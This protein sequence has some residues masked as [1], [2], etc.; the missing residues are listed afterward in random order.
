MT[1]LKRLLCVLLTLL[2]LTAPVAKAEEETVWVLC[3]PGST[4]NIRSRP[5][6]R[7]EV[8]GFADPG[9]SFLTDGRQKSGFLHIY[10]TIEGGEGW[11]SLGYIVH[12]QPVRANERRVIEARGRVKARRTVNGKRRCWLQPG[13][14]VTVYFFAEWCVTSAGFVY[15]EFLGV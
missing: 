13:D 7:S 12:D 8:V 5:S 10:A 1:K 11:I 2:V 14:E 6:G 4:V 9:D 3:Q 15:Y